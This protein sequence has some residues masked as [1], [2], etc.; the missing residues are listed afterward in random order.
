ML[1]SECKRSISQ[2]LQ[3]ILSKKG[4]DASVLL[5]ILDMMKDWIENDFRSSSSGTSN[6]G[7]NKDIILYLQK[8]SQVDRQVL[9]TPYLED[10][11]E[12]YL[13]LRYRLCSDST[14]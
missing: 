3:S 13:Q 4:T 7:L 6:A 9:S 11:D 8:L 14:K 5:T 12:K 1:V 10:W 2:I